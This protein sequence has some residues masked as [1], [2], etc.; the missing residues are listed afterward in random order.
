MFRLG[1]DLAALT[2]G[3]PTGQLTA[4][5]LAILVLSLTDGA[6]LTE[7]LEVAK[8]CLRQEP[9]HE[10]TLRAI[11]QAE[12][13]AGTGT[14][15]AEAI[16]QLGQGW[17]AEEA[18]SIALYCALVVEDFQ[19][20]ITLAVNHDGDSDSTGAIAGNL[21]GAWLGEHSISVA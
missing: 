19:Q 5:I 1:A 3:H 14:P 11:L 20:G 2:H 9:R 15:H 18:L 4:G 13:L 17:I 21:S 10:E 8:A 7:A 16:A 6:T 12:T